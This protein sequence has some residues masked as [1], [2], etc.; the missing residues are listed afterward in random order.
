MRSLQNLKKFHYY[1]WLCTPAL[2][3]PDN[4]HLLTSPTPLDDKELAQRCVKFSQ[5]GANGTAS[6]AFLIVQQANDVELRPLTSLSDSTLEAN[7]VTLVFAD[8]STQNAFPGWPLR[9]L[10][11]AVA[12]EKYPVPTVSYNGLFISDRNGLVS[13]CFVCDSGLHK[14][15]WTLPIARCWILVGMR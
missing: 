3:F 15:S 5:D 4:L 14:A 9:N 2:C 10:I 12:Y 13:R 8:P 11:A 7:H 1:Y 6:H